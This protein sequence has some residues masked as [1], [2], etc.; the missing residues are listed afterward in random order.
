MNLPSTSLGIAANT[1]SKIH[2][3]IC[4]LS[5]SA[6]GPDELHWSRTPKK[7]H[8]DSAESTP[9]INCFW[10]RQGMALCKQLSFGFKNMGRVA[11]W[12]IVEWIYEAVQHKFMIYGNTLLN[13]QRFHFLQLWYTWFYSL[14][15][16]PLCSYSHQWEW[17]YQNMMWARHFCVNS[18][19]KPTLTQ[20]LEKIVLDKL[21][22]SFCPQTFF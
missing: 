12:C 10:N 15:S 1:K 19:P 4:R 11:Q 14:A 16:S 18:S 7:S 9:W 21:N 6:A 17:L 20:C 13:K 22:S 2:F 8:C 3:W 5:K